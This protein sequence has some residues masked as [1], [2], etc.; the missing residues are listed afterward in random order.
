MNEKYLAGFGAGL[1]LIS[2]GIIVSFLVA[3]GVESKAM[4]EN[5]TIGFEQLGELRNTHGKL[6]NYPAT[7]EFR[8]FVGKTVDE[9]KESVVIE[10]STL[11]IVQKNSTVV[12]GTD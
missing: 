7:E 6:R 2:F 9:I 11:Y 5:Q 8:N 12:N 1:L 3:S 4:E 10:N